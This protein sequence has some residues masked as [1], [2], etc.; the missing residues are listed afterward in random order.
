MNKIALALAATVT[1]SLHAMQH[2]EDSIITTIEQ[3]KIKLD[4]L[5]RE[6]QKLSGTLTDLLRNHSSS[7]EHLKM[8]ES[9]TTLIEEKTKQIEQ[10]HAS[11]EELVIKY[12]EQ[13]QN[14]NYVA[15]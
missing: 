5:M 12:E 6:I 11:F 4:S 8:K 13:E 10:E 14:S 7:P 9:L 2:N 1:I 15:K 3:Q